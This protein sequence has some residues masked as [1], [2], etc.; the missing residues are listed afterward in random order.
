MSE[1]NKNYEAQT[2]AMEKCDAGTGT[3][4]WQTK[5]KEFYDVKGKLQNSSNMI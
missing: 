3:N 4:D 5:L 1:F 2:S